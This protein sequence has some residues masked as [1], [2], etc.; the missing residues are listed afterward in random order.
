MANAYILN[1]VP[2]TYGQAISLIVELLV[3]AGWS[4]RG[5]GDGLSGYSAAGKVFTGTGTGAGGW[6][7]ARAWARLAAPDERREIVVQHNNTGG[8][9]LKY[10]A[11]GK[12]VGG[13]PTANTVPSASD[14]RVLWG[15]GTDGTPTIS[16]WFN[17]GILTG[18]NR[19]YGHASDTA[20]FGFWA[21]AITTPAGTV[22]C[23][24]LLDPLSTVPED[25]DPVVFHIGTGLAFSR[26][27]GNISTGSNINQIGAWPASGGTRE[28]SWG[29]MD[30]G[31][32]AFAY[33]MAGMFA[34][35]YMYN[36]A[37]NAPAYA[38]GNNCSPLNPF[39]GKNEALPILWGRPVIGSLSL[40]NTGIKGWSRF[41]R[42]TGTSRTSGLDTLDGLRWICMGYVWLPWDGVTTPIN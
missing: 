24:L 20:P 27:I 33:V 4:Y 3:A 35:G 13:T 8:L 34:V 38:G 28:G 39:N 41:M 11:V 2:T 18:A 15:G 40:A 42:W 12:F 23:G 16:A 19:F 9:R 26:G 7:N 37:A 1:A 25:P 17:S 21:G 10:S 29:H 5:S 14:E 31:M 6:A 22:T 30:L 32:T 36:D